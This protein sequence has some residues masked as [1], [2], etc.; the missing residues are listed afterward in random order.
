VPLALLPVAR[1]GQ[2]STKRFSHYRASKG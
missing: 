1:T 2:H